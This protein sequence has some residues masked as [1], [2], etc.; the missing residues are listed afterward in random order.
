MLGRR[1]LPGF[2]QLR[3]WHLAPA[4]ESVHHR[5]VPCATELNDDVVDDGCEP[6]VADECETHGV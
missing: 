3:V 2:P 1:I 6:G 4:D 5:L